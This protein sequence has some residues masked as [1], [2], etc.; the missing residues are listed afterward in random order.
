MFCQQYVFFSNVR[1]VVALST[2]HGITSWSNNEAFVQA[3]S[4][5][6]FAERHALQ[7]I[8]SLLVGINNFR[9][10]MQFSFQSV[11]FHSVVD[12]AYSNASQLFNGL[13]L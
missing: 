8:F 5:F 9:H 3:V 4:V 7:W 12:K 6:D 10:S 13:P 2:C 11:G 1:Q